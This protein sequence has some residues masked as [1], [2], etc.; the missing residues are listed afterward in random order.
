[1]TEFVWQR[2]REHAIERFHETPGADAEQRILTIF[3]QHPQTVAALI[4]NVAARVDIG[5]IRSGWAILALECERAAERSTITATDTKD[6]TRATK[7][8][9]QWMRAAGL[10]FDLQ[11]ELE[12]ELYGDR[13][14]LRHW[15][16]TTNDTLALWQQLR[17]AGIRIEQEAQERADAWRTHHN[18]VTEPPQPKPWPADQPAPD[19]PAFTPEGTFA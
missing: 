10:H 3:Q 5:A 1:M 4:D 9:D 18:P 17:P 7:R 6:K 19:E 11:A 13:G 12:D 14:P 16:E 15:P 2:L 8:T